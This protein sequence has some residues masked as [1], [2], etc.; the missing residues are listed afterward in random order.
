VR[1]ALKVG[2]STAGGEVF[3]PVMILAVH[4]CKS[5]KKL[6]SAARYVVGA[7]HNRQE[8][9]RED[10]GLQDYC[11]NDHRSYISINVEI[12]II[13]AFVGP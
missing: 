4:D 10:E 6:R 7:S 13:H 9:Q 1:S 8:R 2:S 5:V 11:Q 12:A 3:L